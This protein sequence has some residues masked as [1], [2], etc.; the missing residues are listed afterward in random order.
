M[1]EN[2]VD[3]N[4]LASQDSD[5]QPLRQLREELQRSEENLR[6]SREN[7]SV[8][9]KKLKKARRDFLAIFDSVPAMIWYRDREGKILRVNRCAAD[10]IGA[11]AKELIGQNYYDLFPEQADR[12]R[13]LDQQVIQTG[14]GIFGQL[15]RFTTFDSHC[16]RWAMVDRIPLRDRDGRIEGVILFAQDITEKKQAEERLLVAQKEIELRNEQLRAAAAKAEKLAESAC[17]SNRAK[18]EILA[19]SSHDL[20]TPMNAIL[21]FTDLLMETSLDDEQKQYVSTIQDAARGL[22]SLINDILDFAKL[23]AGKFKI[24]IVPCFL[25]EF[26]G[27]IRA[28][29]ET[30]ARQKGLEFRVEIDSRLPRS[31]YTDPLRLKQCLVNLLGNAIKFTESGHVGLRVLAHQQAARPCIQFE[32]E[33]TG[34][35]IPK[36]RQEEIFKSFAQADVTTAHKYGGSGLG[37]TLTRRLTD[38]LG[39]T[40][41]VVSEPGCGSTFAIT[42]PILDKQSGLAD[43]ETRVQ[44]HDDAQLPA[45]KILLAEARVPSQLTMNLLLRRAGLDVQAV[46]GGRQAV[47]KL[48]TQAFDLLLL[49]G[50]MSAEA[51]EVIGAIRAEHSDLPVI[52][53]VDNDASSR[54]ALLDAGADEVLLR[55]ITRRVLYETIAE[56]IHKTDYHKKLVGLQADSGPESDLPGLGAPHEIATLLAALLADLRKT[57]AE[58]DHGRAEETLRVLRDVSVDFDCPEWNG[59]LNQLTQQLQRNA[60]DA[61][62]LQSIADD[63]SGICGEIF[64]AAR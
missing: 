15:R 57:L 30:G 8:S 60:Q 37:L 56:Q 21:G 17:Q 62:L 36:D 59:K 40:L 51:V 34:I 6:L 11:T 5:S 23:E 27:Q 48:R 42:L 64:N 33:D 3:R 7:Q 9:I 63:L 2:R 43:A 53:L 50:S 4:S 58:S 35:G 49:D 38:L 29:M 24:D 19:S 18:S 20:R 45:W 1:G 10:S 55:P 16:V 22:L 14:I 61:D 44:R 39:G 26:V 31:F 47:E 28:M 13:R 32:I 46:A 25:D 52:V 41:R 54:E 12:S